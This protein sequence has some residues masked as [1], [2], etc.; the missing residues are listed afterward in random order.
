MITIAVVAT[1]GG[2][3]KTTTT[4]NLGAL[5]ADLGARVLLIDCDVQPSLSRYFPLA[6]QA[7]H[8]LT[9]VVK[10]GLITPQCISTLGVYHAE[11]GL[12]LNS[13]GAFDIVVSDNIEGNLQ[14]WLGPRIDRGVRIKRAIHTPHVNENYD[15]VIIDTQGAVGHLQDAA[16]LAAD[17]LLSPISPDIL[18]AREFTSGTIELLDRLEPGSEIGLSVPPM[19][20]L[21]YRQERTRDSRQIAKTIREQYVTLRARVNVLDCCVPYAVAYKNAATAQIPVHWID[22]A[23]AHTMHKLVWEL[24]PSFEGLVAPSC[25]GQ[26]DLSQFENGADEEGG[27]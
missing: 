12:K 23:A 24:I 17:M 5:L 13:D 11:S 6:H 18:S 2:V 14:D 1:K 15:I 7:P 9:E 3:G 4:A 19:Q 27:A 21:I 26:F 25:I 16:V 22:A 10:R 20:A 8:G